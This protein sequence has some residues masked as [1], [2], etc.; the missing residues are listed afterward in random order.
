[1]QLGLQNRRN[2]SV[3]MIFATIFATQNTRVF[4]NVSDVTLLFS[5]SLKI[6][7]TKNYATMMATS[8]LLLLRHCLWHR[9]ARQ[10]TSSSITLLR[11]FDRRYV[12]AFVVGSQDYVQH[13]ASAHDIKIFFSF[14]VHR[15][16]DKR[17]LWRC[18]RTTWTIYMYSRLGCTLLANLA[19]PIQPKL[20]YILW[21]A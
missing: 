21:Y 15:I 4:S 7:K 18:H 10:P 19:P 16:I 20:T 11:Y 17:L 5:P 13:S 9:H 8:S 1:M 2:M 14:Y 6:Y 12:T 3:R